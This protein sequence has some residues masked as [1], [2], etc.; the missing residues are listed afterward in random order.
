MAQLISCPHCKQALNLP[1]GFAATQVRC[2]RCK[3]PFRLP[4]TTAV[5]AAPLRPTPTARAEALSPPLPSAAAQ[6]PSWL[7]FRQWPTALRLLPAGLLA[8]I[9][10]AFMVRD[11]FVGGET[12]DDEPETAVVELPIDPNPL[13]NI[14]YHQPNFGLTTNKELKDGTDS[15]RLTFT[16]HGDTN[17]AVARIDGESF[18]FGK[19]SISVGGSGIKGAQDG[20][21][22]ETQQPRL[23]YGRWINPPIPLGKAS[24]GRERIGQS[25]SY[26]YDEQKI[27]VTQTVEI[28][29]GE[30]A[31]SGQ[32][33]RHLDT[34][35]VRYRLDNRDDKSHRLA[36][37]F[38]LDTFIGGNDGVP[39]TIPG[40]TGLCDTCKDFA[41]P[42]HVPDFLQALER[43]SLDNPGTIAHLTLRLGGVLEP[44]DRVT[45]GH[46]INQF[47]WRAGDEPHVDWQFPV[48]PLRDD[49]C[50]VLYWKEKELPA[51]GHRELGFA[52]G[53]G[54]VSSGEGGGKLGLTVGGSFRPGEEFTVT[55]YVH[56]P[57]PNQT[58][59]LI[60]PRGLT[61]TDGEATR[62]VPPLPDGAASRN[63]P[64]TW[65]VKA[66]RPGR[67]S[68]RVKT[69]NG[70]QQ[71][72]VVTV[73]SNGIFD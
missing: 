41:P 9:L 54:H 23:F 6:A 24:D 36:F 62:N 45:L 56:E 69:N 68:L 65:K 38:V 17:N 22:D 53:L 61:R 30:Q 47:R 39:F 48:E 32:T 66:A 55:A 29:P 16:P 71:T 63:S 13:L 57:L 73:T 44:P 21:I 35:L 58:V 2:P 67:F 49:S 3:E 40:E 28:V 64:V 34:C 46:W 50:V 27:E 70:L 10:L 42:D 31:G 8:F 15:K 60:L 14:R 51:G 7:D 20:R 25:S 37:R 12:D 43:P 19:F 4:G 52:Y 33:H 11:R 26:R 5:T 72:Q 18:V 1:D 59:S